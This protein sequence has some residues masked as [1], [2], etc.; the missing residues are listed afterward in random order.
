MLLKSIFNRKTYYDIANTRQNSDQIHWL[1]YHPI[2]T[3]VAILLPILI[4]LILKSI[5]YL[6]VIIMKKSHMLTE[7]LTM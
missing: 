2:F 6:P 4:L 7:N 1:I 3:I 5:G